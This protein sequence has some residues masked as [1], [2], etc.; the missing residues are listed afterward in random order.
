MFKIKLIFIE[1]NINKF[2]LH[3]FLSSVVVSVKKKMCI[4]L[5]MRERIYNKIDNIIIALSI[6]MYI[7]QFVLITCREN[8]KS[9]T[10]V[11]FQTLL[12]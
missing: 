10:V 2:F 11:S 4:N 3:V 9:S 8:N 12:S 7:K 1:I 5:L 6:L